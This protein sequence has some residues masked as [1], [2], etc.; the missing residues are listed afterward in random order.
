MSEHIQIG[1]RRPW[2]QYEVDETN[3]TQPFPYP[4]PIFE[5]ADLEVYVGTA[6]LTVGQDYSVTDAGMSE[7]GT[8]VFSEPPSIGSRV[9]LRRRL[10]IQRTSD[11]QES[12]EFRAKVLNDELD[13]QTAAIQQVADDVTRSLRLPATDPDSGLMLPA[14]ELR[15]GRFL[16]FDENGGPVAATGVTEIP[17]SPF[18][19]GVLDDD[20]PGELMRTVALTPV[21]ETF[22]SGSGAVGNAGTP[23]ELSH[24]PSSSEDVFVWVNNVPQL[25]NW[26]LDGK[27]F[28]FDFTP[29]EGD[30]VQIRYRTGDV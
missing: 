1:D 4:F 21:N 7:G 13:Y 5:D 2:V 30:R 11:F 26:E 24:S 3:R 19:E 10:D 16:A 12:G 22:V 8:V 17:V 18:M 9:T 15:T 23:F 29:A 28:H 25:A 27:A 14:K 6:L 20:D